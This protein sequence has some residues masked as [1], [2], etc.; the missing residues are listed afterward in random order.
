M[1]KASAII[2]DVGGVT[3][4]MA[5]LAR[6]FQ[7][8]AILDTEIATDM[9]WNGQEITVD[10]I[11][12]NVYDGH[13]HELEEFAQKK[14]DHLSDTPLFHTFERALKMIVPL[15]LVDP[16]SED[17][18]P[19]SC[20]TLHDITRFAHEK[21]MYEMFAINDCTDMKRG[22][23]IK[24]A[25]GI[26]TE[27]YVLDL[28]GGVDEIAL[29]KRTITPAEVTSLPLNAFLKGLTSMRWP[30]AAPLD[31]KGFMG[32]IAQTASIPEADLA[33]AGE[34]S[35]IFISDKYMNFALRLGYHLSTVEAYAGSN[36]NNNYIK[37]F[38]KGGGAVRD[39]RL[40]RVR[41]ITEILKAMDF[42]VKVIEDVVEAMLTK[43][44]QATIMEKLEVLGKLTVYTKQ[45]DMVMYN[46][47]VTDMYIK[48]FIKKYLTKME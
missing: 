34:N 3:G 26:P 47:A 31:A 5:S 38:F 32:M 12:C 45:L 30:D 19:E 43:Y 25:A 16:D 2:T 23:G 37:F 6:E 15:N 44:K 18:R 4:H 41:L 39:R 14:E 28:G 42:N 40:R 9:I 1:E 7:V 22:A 10:A 29:E 11:N 13:V 8:P 46:D 36:I 35:F 27:I 20:K 48:E 17:F 33:K 21:G 24:L